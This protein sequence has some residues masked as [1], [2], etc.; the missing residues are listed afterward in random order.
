MLRGQLYQECETL[1]CENEPVCVVC[2]L[3]SKHC[4]CEAP[5]EREPV[6]SKPEP[7][8]DAR[9]RI[10]ELT[11]GWSKIDEPPVE[12]KL[13]E[14]GQEVRVKGDGS[15]YHGGNLYVEAKIKGME[16]LAEYYGNAVV[17]WCRPG[18]ETQMVNKVTPDL[19]PEEV[20]RYKNQVKTY[21]ECLCSRWMEIWLDSH[22]TRC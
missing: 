9:P 17:L 15:W 8:Q 10:A 11:K 2:L 22:P 18:M 12:F 7:V 14:V 6:R 16:V 4:S 13:E 21:P 5:S 20:Q 19:S 3:C 1:G